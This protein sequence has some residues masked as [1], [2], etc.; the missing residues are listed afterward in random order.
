LGVGKTLDLDAFRLQQGVFEARYE[1][2][3]LLW[4]K[5][6]SIW[7]AM[8]SSYPTLR[9]IN[10]Q[11]AVTTF[12]LGSK[13]E[14]S[15]EVDKTTTKVHNPG[16]NLDEFR[17]MARDLLEISSQ[18]LSVRTFTRLG[19][20]IIFVKDYSTADEASTTMLH[21]N[22]MQIP[23]GPRFG[24]KDGRIRFPDYSIRWENEDLGVL[25]RIKVEPR[26]YRIELPFAWEGP[27]ADQAPQDDVFGLI[28][29]VDYYT[30]SFVDFDQLNVDEWIHSRYRSI[31]RELERILQ[32]D[33]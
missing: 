31:R 3:W 26:P 9:L 10:A 29:D 33:L 16:N 27:G 18:N 21:L 14:F 4:D 22:L 19:L 23:Q 13:Y 24:V 12:R 11:P 15:V 7:T 5:A 8:V 28:L 30:K 17:N 32:G 20:R 2:G 6:G 1:H 25:M